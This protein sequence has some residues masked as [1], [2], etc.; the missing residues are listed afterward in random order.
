MSRFEFNKNVRTFWCKF[1]FN[2]N[3]GGVKCVTF[4]GS[5]VRSVT[6]RL[7]CF[8]FSLLQILYFYFK[9]FARNMQRQIVFIQGN[10]RFSSMFVEKRVVNCWVKW[11]EV[12]HHIIFK[13]RDVT[14][15]HVIKNF[16]LSIRIFYSLDSLHMQFSFS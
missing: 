1:F 11:Q 6:K 15:Y 10:N 8:L 16:F 4:L 5:A 14:V 13:F 12:N 7:T 3:Y 9:M 2:Q